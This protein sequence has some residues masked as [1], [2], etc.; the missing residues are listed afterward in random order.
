MEQVA[1]IL[2]D[3][4]DQKGLVYK[5]SKLFYELDLNII[6]NQEFVDKKNSHFFMRSVVAGSFDPSDLQLAL[7]KVIG[8]DTNVRVITPKKKNIIL[9]VTKESHA[10]GDLLIRHI[11]GELEANIVAVIGNRDNLQSLV[12]RFGIPF[13]HKCRGY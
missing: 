8:N 13:I 6:S 1:R 4:K 10:L 5:V 12:E 3:C 7:N 2:I 11:D 9:M